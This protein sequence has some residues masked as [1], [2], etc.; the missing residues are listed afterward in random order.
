M[1]K[2]K[3]AHEE[4]K[5]HPVIVLNPES[6]YPF[7]FGVPKAKLILDHIEDIRDFVMANE[8]GDEL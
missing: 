8:G 6:K 4:F 2:Q 5:G 1:G 3:V 7:S